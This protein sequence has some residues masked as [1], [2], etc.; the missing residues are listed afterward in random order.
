[1][2]IHLENAKTFAANAQHAARNCES[3]TVGGGKFDAKELASVASI[4]SAIGPAVKVLTEISEML[5]K[6]PEFAQGN[7]TVH[8]CAHKAKTALSNFNYETEDSEPAAP[9]PRAMRP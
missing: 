9:R 8:Y 3:I 2:N 7:S 6:H 5:G 1:M 4:L